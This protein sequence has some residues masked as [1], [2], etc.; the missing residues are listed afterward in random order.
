MN[1]RYFLKNS[2]IALASLGVATMSP[3]FLTRTLAQTDRSG[4][5]RILIA[6]FQR[7]AMDG[8]NAVVP[9][10]EPEYY[11]LRPSIAIP[12]P[13]SSAPAGQGFNAVPGPGID[14]DGF[15]GLHPSL[16]PFK[17]LYD[18]GQLAIVHAVG[19]PDSTRSH[20]DAQDFMEA[21]TPGVPDSI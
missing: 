19:S 8:L 4:R 16:A 13:G 1:R 2:G 15:F 17:P 18:S 3:S 12:R 14:L 10:G 11:S 21:G 6:I 7:G 20:F 5:R 9:Y